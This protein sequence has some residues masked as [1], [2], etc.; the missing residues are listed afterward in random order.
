M[1]DGSSRND[2]ATAGSLPAMRGT[3]P[4]SGVPSLSRSAAM[5]SSARGMSGS[6]RL[7]T[8]P[9]SLSPRAAMASA[10]SRA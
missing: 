2:A 5:L 6:I 9:A 7:A 3:A 10:V 8:Q 1:P 4:S